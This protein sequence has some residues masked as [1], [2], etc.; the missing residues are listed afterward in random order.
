[1]AEDKEQIKTKTQLKK[2]VEA[3]E[4]LVN[5]KEAKDLLDKEVCITHV[6]GDALFLTKDGLVY[7]NIYSVCNMFDEAESDVSRTQISREKYEKIILKLQLTEK[8]INEAHRSL[9]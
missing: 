3:L 9:L 4:L 7:Q 5:S 6:S 2:A 1:M 8:S